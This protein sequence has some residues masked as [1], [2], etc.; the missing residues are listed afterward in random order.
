MVE[1][2]FVHSFYCEAHTR[3]MLTFPDGICHCIEI[4]LCIFD[5]IVCILTDKQNIERYLVSY[6]LL[7]PLQIKSPVKHI[8]R[9]TNV[10][11]Y[12]SSK[13]REGEGGRERGICDSCATCRDDLK[14]KNEKNSQCFHGKEPFHTWQDKGFSF[15]TLI[16]KRIVKLIVL[17]LEITIVTPAS[18]AAQSFG[19]RRIYVCMC[20]YLSIIFYIFILVVLFKKNYSA[21]LFPMRQF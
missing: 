4:H 14:W 9:S 7:P 12:S 16:F 1:M 19:F 18:R 2:P 8:K 13:R 20:I 3:L 5:L 21:V 11:N 6:Y 17:K 15:V 10:Q